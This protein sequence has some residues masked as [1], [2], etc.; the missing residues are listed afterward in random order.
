[1]PLGASHRLAPSGSSKL[2]LDRKT[3]LARNLRRRRAARVP[4]HIDRDVDR[5]PGFSSTT[6]QDVVL[7]DRP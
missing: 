7:D 3:G 2:A 1:M 4:G 6:D 5:V